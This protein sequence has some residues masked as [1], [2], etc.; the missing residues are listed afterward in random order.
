MPYDRSRQNGEGFIKVCCLYL[1]LNVGC[2]LDDDTAIRWTLSYMTTGQA[3]AWRDVAIDHY[4]NHQKYP[5]ANMKA[6]V[7]AFNAEFLPVAEAEEAMVKLEGRMYFQKAHESA[8]AYIHGFRDL[9][10][11]A[12][13]TDI[14]SI[15]IKFRPG[16]QDSLARTLADSPDP[17]SVNDVEDWYHRTHKLEHSRTIQQTI[18]GT[19]STAPPTRSHFLTALRRDHMATPPATTLRTPTTN[20]SLMVLPTSALMDM[21]ATRSR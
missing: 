4:T 6:L 15:V 14:T 10:K 21:D 3:Q 12:G 13:L 8:D 5:W 20:P 9:V 17:P 7:T 19:R 2:F 18:F 11:K 1:Q 16:L